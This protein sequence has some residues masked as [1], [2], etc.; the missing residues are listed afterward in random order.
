MLGSSSSTVNCVV[1][2]L[3]LIIKPPLFL[4]SSSEN[5]IIASLKDIMEESI[6][7][8]IEFILSL[9]FF[10]EREENLGLISIWRTLIC[11]PLL[12]II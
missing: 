9:A 5:L 2:F 12:S 1:P 7:I 8:F 4:L 3:L 10:K 11:S 6:S